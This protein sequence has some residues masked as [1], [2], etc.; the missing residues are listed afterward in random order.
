VPVRLVTLPA[1]PCP[2]LPDRTS[3]SRALWAER[4]PPELY[5][6]FMDAGFRR[7]GQLIY[8][9]VCNGCRACVPLRVPVERFT[10]SKS[11]RRCCRRNADVVVTV[12]EPE[13]T[14]EKYDLYRRYVTQWHGK[15]AEDETRDGFEQFLY[16]SPVDTV[17][18]VHRDGQGKLLAVGLC[19]V[20]PGSLSTV[21]FYFDPSESRRGLGT[22]GAVYEIEAARRLGI[23]YYYLGYW[24]NGC[25]AME[26]KASFRPSELLH[27]DGVW[28]AS[29][30]PSRAG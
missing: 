3:V 14:D 8:Q 18:F 13:A 1:Q 21:Y 7:S 22:F 4:M 16:D 25:G 29:A 20:S 5:H 12:A 2:Y 9:P 24:I 27:P 28:R 26:Y 6:G 11:Q 10:P 23:P 15:S 30:P 19:D 17:E